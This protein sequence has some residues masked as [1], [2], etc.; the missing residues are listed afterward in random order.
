[1]SPTLLLAMTSVLLAHFGQPATR[2]TDSIVPEGAIV[3]PDPG[4]IVDRPPRDDDP[5]QKRSFTSGETGVTLSYLV[6]LPE[7]YDDDPDRDWP[8]VIFLHGIGERGDD[9][10]KVKAW[11]PPRM[12]A[13]GQRYDA[14]VVSPQCPESTWWPREV[15]TLDAFLDKVIDDYRVD[16]DRVLLTGLS[17]GGYGTFAWGAASPERFAALAPVC[18]AGDAASAKA[19]GESGVPIR[20]FHG[21]DDPVVPAAQSMMMYN[22]IKAAREDGGAECELT[23]FEGVAHLSWP[24]VYEDEPFWSWLLAQKRGD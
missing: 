11:G 19:I 5:Q 12:I 15:E 23:L 2:P 1:M 8:L 16:E 9:A 17:M 21:L 18:G 6:A 20:M 4:E 22:G 3:L 10:N 7:G 14:I 13:A 24:Y